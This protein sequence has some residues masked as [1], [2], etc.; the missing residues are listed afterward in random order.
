MN[1]L[2]T[3]ILKRKL[4]RLNRKVSFRSL[5]HC[6]T[7]LIAYNCSQSDL[8]K[9]VRAFARQLKEEGLNVTTLGYYDIKDKNKSKPKDELSYHYFDRKEVNYFGLLKNSQLKRLIVQPFDL[10]IDL[11]LKGDFVLRS[12]SSLSKAKFKVGIENEYALEVYD[13]TVNEKNEDIN[14]VCKQILHY[15]KMIKA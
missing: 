13:L 11:N 6:D 4:K 3:N 10:M 9:S 2:K 12:I 7:A 1:Q 14:Q 8:E 15:L 5:S